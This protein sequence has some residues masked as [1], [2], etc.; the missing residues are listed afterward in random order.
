MHVKN[1]D[2]ATFTKELNTTRNT[3]LYIILTTDED[4]SRPV[5]ISGNFNNWRTQDK[6]FMMEKIGNSLYHSLSSVSVPRA[7]SIN[8]GTMI[9]ATYPGLMSRI[10]RVIISH[11]V[12][13]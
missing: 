8:S 12:I 6:E 1:P 4:D 5:Y 10:G 9:T 13:T 3:G 11:A 7:R 2:N